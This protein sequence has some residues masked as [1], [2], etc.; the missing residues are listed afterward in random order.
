M[1]SDDGSWDP[2]LVSTTSPSVRVCVHACLL[3]RVHGSCVSQAEAIITKY[4]NTTGNTL[5]TPELNAVGGD[6]LC[7]LALDK[8]QNISYQSLR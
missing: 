6:N 4:L 2:S 3:S 7:S 8:I 5:G 1:N